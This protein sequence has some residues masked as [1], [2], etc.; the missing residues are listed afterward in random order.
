MSVSKVL[1]IA[2][3]EVGYLEKATNANLYSKTGNAGYNNFTKYAYEIDTKYPSFYNGGKNGYAWCDL[4]VDWCFIQAYGEAG[5]RAALCQPVKSAGAGC[6]Y[7]AQDYK[8]AGR[9]GTTPKV[10]AQIFFKD[11]SGDVCHTGIVYAVDNNK[12]YTVEGNTSSASGVVANGGG[13]AEKSYT[14][15]YIRIYGYGYPIY[16]DD[17]NGGTEATGTTE[18]AAKATNQLVTFKEWKTYQNG[19]TEEPVYKDTEFTEKTGSLNP[20]EQ[21]YCTGRYGNAY[22]IF[23]KIDNTDDRWATGYVAYNGGI[24]E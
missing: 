13:V 17:S 2:R 12:V 20:W 4:F 1:A 8:N 19:S 16:Q 14:R 18:T 6:Y 15:E 11:S 24:T 23:Y 22:H 9:V 10:G 5:A 3:G 7:S 21:C